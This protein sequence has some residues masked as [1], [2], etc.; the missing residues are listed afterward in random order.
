MIHSLKTV[1]ST[2]C[3]F[4]QYTL[5]GTFLLINLRYW[6][7]SPLI[8]YFIVVINI[9]I[10][11]SF[12]CLHGFLKM[13]M[14]QSIVSHILTNF[15]VFSNFF[16]P[17]QG[18]LDLFFFPGGSLGTPS[19]PKL[20][21]RVVDGPPQIISKVEDTRYR[22]LSVLCS[23]LRGSA[24][25]ERSSKGTINRDVFFCHWSLSILKGIY[26]RDRYFNFPPKALRS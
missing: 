1:L 16:S 2:F 24:Q 7:S 12:Y 6:V 21:P 26:R 14:S 5:T 11:G 8:Y 25:T 3:V 4:S 17:K 15:I 9:I 13:Y 19:G 18:R 10:L 22:Y 23:L 20:L